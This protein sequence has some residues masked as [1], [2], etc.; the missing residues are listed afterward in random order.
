MPSPPWTR[1]HWN[2]LCQVSRTSISQAAGR[3]QGAF[4]R[5]SLAGQPS[6][7]TLRRWVYFFICCITE[8]PSCTLNKQKK[9]L[10]RMLRPT[11]AASHISPAMK[12][13]G[14]FKDSQL[15]R[16]QSTISPSVLP[17][18]HNCKMTSCQVTSRHWHPSA[19]D[20]DED[21]KF[22]GK[23]KLFWKYTV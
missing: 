19:W 3:E 2:F 14:I 23:W 10:S 20:R 8:V 18:S 17:E 9:P 12:L 22:L 4:L 11:R 5:S 16:P 1:W 21:M 13:A 15:P 7:D 6:G